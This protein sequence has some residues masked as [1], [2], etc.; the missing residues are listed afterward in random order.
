MGKD[1]SVLISSVEIKNFRCFSHIQFDFSAPYVLLEG[2]NGIGKTSILEAL[3][4]ACY[5]RSFRTHIP[6]ELIAFNQQ[7]LFIKVTVDTPD[8]LS[9]D[10]Q[11]GMSHN[12]RLVRVDQRPV[13]SYKELMA[14]YR[15]ISLTED[16]LALIQ[17]SPQYRRL[18]LDQMLLL[19]NPEFGQVLKDYRQIVDQRN[20]YLQQHR[21]D[22]DTYRAL[23]HQQ[24]KQAQQIELKRRE[25]LDHLFVTVNSLNERFLADGYK[26]HFSYR[27]KKVLC[28]SFEA[29]YADH[30][31]LKEQEFRYGRSFFG[32]H[33]DDISI[34]FRDRYSRT[35][36][37]RGQQKMILLLLKIAQLQILSEMG[38][39]SI[40][41]LDD[42]MTDFDENRALEL[43]SAL[44]S[45]N[46][47]LIFTSP[48][49]GG[50]LAQTV[51][52]ESGRILKLTM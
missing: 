32:V 19:L 29:F 4:Y 20:A 28:D 10:I 8:G 16:D 41:L 48:M 43:I 47:Q 50:L 51:E 6:K 42:F 45:L 38:C 23:T 27:P 9:H 15:I 22:E 12:K 14:Y 46:C 25:L 49:V 35:Y 52:R 21:R 1:T 36:A 3:Y 2:V 39:P 5:L 26:I 24:W 34:T 31:R 11:I 33:L 17:G 44:K 18:F 30:A 7:E 40:F 13:S 37:S